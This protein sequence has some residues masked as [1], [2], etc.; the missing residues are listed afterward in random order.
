MSL[1]KVLEAEILNYEQG[2]PTKK[3]HVTPAGRKVAPKVAIT[4]TRERGALPWRSSRLD[5]AGGR[6]KA[7]PKRRLAD[8]DWLCA[9]RPR[10]DPSWLPPGRGATDSD[11]LGTLWILARRPGPDSPGEEP[12]PLRRHHAPPRGSGLSCDSDGLRGL[13]TPSATEGADLPARPD[14]VRSGLVRSTSFRVSPVWPDGLIPGQ[15]RA[16][17]RGGGAARPVGGGRRP[18]AARPGQPAACGR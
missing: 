5:C 13:A 3:A 2:E 4:E 7:S 1:R 8:W 6:R 16:S 15:R 10:R 9:C 14:P 18:A 11:G 12:G 17:S